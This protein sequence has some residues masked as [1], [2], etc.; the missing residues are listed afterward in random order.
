MAAAASALAVVALAADPSFDPNVTGVYDYVVVGAGSAG[1]PLAARLAKAG[2]SVLLLEAGPDNDWK[3]P[4]P[5]NID[6][7]VPRNARSLLNLEGMGDAVTS[8]PV[9]PFPHGG[10]PN[11]IN[12]AGEKFANRSGDGR[13]VKTKLGE[14]SPRG[15]I[16]GGCSMHN[17]MIFLRGSPE[18]YESWGWEWDTV[19][20][21]YMD[22]ENNTCPN[23]DDGFHGHQG[24]CFVSSVMDYITPADKAWI[25]AAAKAGLVT[26]NDFNGAKQLGAGSFPTSTH[27]G[28]RWSAGTAFLTSTVRAL[29]NFKLLTGAMVTKVRFNG[30]RAVGVSYVEDGAPAIATATKEVILTAGT[31]RSPQ[32]LMLSGVGP[33]DVLAKFS[34]PTVAANEVV[35]KHLQDHVMTPVA[36]SALNRK[37]PGPEYPWMPI[38]GFYHS[39]WCKARNCTHHDMQIHCGSAAVGIACLPT[40]VGYIQSDTGYLTLASA[41][42][43]DYPA[44]YPNY[45]TAQEDM[46]RM[47]EGIGEAQRIFKEDRMMFPVLQPLGKNLTEV[48]LKTAMTVYHPAGTCRMGSSSDAAVVDP[49]LRVYG[50]QGLRV[51]DASI[52]P[53][54][55][56]VNT[57]AP[58][59]MIGYHA[60]DIILTGRNQ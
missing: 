55:T 54:I 16:V 44:I 1:S 13:G 38:G 43:Q 58:S 6:P 42:V 20:K 41:D 51:A 39:S 17:N 18:I 35:G 60:A 49:Q 29:P 11:G 50:V 48:V 37:V 32:L 19:K 46:D 28:R 9:W 45:F 21:A 8:E 34:I 36:S 30:T 24:E 5:E 12:A 7:M 2:H 25:K 10:Y 53:R 3:G 56:N 31:F 59:R 14:F 26:N 40:L 33:A 22:L 52:M 47:V 15:R 23:E 4:P 27:N 57:D